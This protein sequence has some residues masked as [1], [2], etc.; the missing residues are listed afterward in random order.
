MNLMN[1]IHTLEEDKRI[2]AVYLLGS[3][4]RGELR[5]DSDIDL[6]LLL[7]NGETIG[8]KERADLAGRL[9]YEMGRTVDIGIVSSKNL[10][11]AKE[12]LL[13]G[14][15]IFDRDRSRSTVASATLLG[16]YIRFN[17]DRKEVLDAYRTR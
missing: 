9:S 12:A 11:Y 5:K 3:G 16:M 1:I 7:F 17:E 8:A 4:A 13:T 6:G 15:K 2:L 14:K 10:V